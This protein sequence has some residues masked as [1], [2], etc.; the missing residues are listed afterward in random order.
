MRLAL[1]AIIIAA[2]TADA[3]TFPDAHEKPPAAWKGPVF[4]LSQDYP[5]RPSTLQAYPWKR[6][7]FATQ[8]EQYIRAVYAYALQGNVETEW[9]GYDNPTRKWFHAPWMHF[10]ESG[11][12]FIHGLTR[13][14]N[15]RPREL[16]QTQDCYWQNWAVGLYNEPGGYVV[17]QVWADPKK[18]DAT[19]A[20]FPDGTVSIKLLFTT[21]PES[22][23]PYLHDG[24][25]WQGNI[26]PVGA[27]D[28]SK[29]DRS[30][31]RTPTDKMTLLQIDLAVRD[32]R[33][34]ATTG[35]VMGTF[36]YDGNAKGATPWERMVPVG[37]QWGNDPALTPQR[38]ANGESVKESWINPKIEVP[39]HLGWLGRLN[40]PV[41]NSESACLS[42]HGTAQT[43][44]SSP[45]VPPH[46]STDTERMRW[47]RNVRTDEAF[48][49]GGPKNPLPLGYSLQL[50]VGIQNQQRA[51]GAINAEVTNGIVVMALDTDKIVFPVSREEGSSE[52][53]LTS[54]RAKVPLS[55]DQAAAPAH[56][57]NYDP[58]TIAG[59]LVWGVVAGVATSALLFLLGQMFV[60]ILI[61]WYQGLI[62]KGVDLR[63]KWVSQRSFQSG[64][65]YHY[66]L[67]LKQNANTLSGSMTISKINS[68]PGPPGGHLGDYVQGFEVN[69]TTWEGFVTLNMTSD[70]RRNL[71]FVTSLLQISNRGQALVGH[72]AY[73]SSVAD[74]VD[75]EEI[76]WTRS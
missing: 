47:F 25:R 64:I 19:R 4:R 36:V 59:A 72:M 73:R 34:G 12:E 60:K 31:V 69:G 46:N 38:H 53:E 32:N 7:A 23:V 24:Y 37:V 11:R 1:V 52:F 51:D 49:T 56:M 61:P 48:D 27:D 58:S 71:S 76:T 43:P 65:I 21:A 39:Q 57:L 28:C 54:D 75:S 6:Y 15:S 22:Q 3:A 63:G 70:D 13:E 74:Q 17:G 44:D 50:A 9:H 42:C 29:A 35:W 16:A 66:S 67:V 18:P 55:S 68:Q 26:D 20:K 41:D 62:F 30:G 33:A 5:T 14:R 45:M 2:T 8:P 10:G 40:G